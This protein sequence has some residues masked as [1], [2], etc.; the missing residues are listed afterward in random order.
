MNTNEI[1]LSGVIILAAAALLSHQA[2]ASIIPDTEP[3]TLNALNATSG[4]N[5]YAVWLTNKTA[6]NKNAEVVIQSFC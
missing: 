3:I 6:N 2:Y 1:I 5:V 4:D